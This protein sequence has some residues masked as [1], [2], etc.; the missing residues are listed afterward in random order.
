MAQ[1]SPYL[2][3][4]GNCEEAFNYYKSIF[5]GKFASVSRFKDMPPMPGF[6]IDPKYGDR[7][8]NMALPISKEVALMGSDGNPNFGKVPF[9]KNV[10]LSV[11]AD[12]KEQ[13]D[14]F[15]NGLAKNGKIE[16]PIADAFWGSYFGMAED[17]FGVN[18]MVSFEYPK[19]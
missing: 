11:V 2:T 9:G 15:F 16:M 7:I 18:W 12:S 19:K 10:T 17:Q 13:A 14:K 8:M 5:G 6:E 3:F 1:L 4:N